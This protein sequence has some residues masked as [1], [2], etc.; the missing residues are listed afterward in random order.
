MSKLSSRGHLKLIAQFVLLGSI[1]FLNQN[2]RLIFHLRDC[3][4]SRKP[5]TLRRPCGGGVP[6]P[7]H[8][9][10]TW[11]LSR[12]AVIDPSKLTNLL[13]LLVC[14]VCSGTGRTHGPSLRTLSQVPLPLIQMQISTHTR[15]NA[16]MRIVV[17][18]DNTQQARLIL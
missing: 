5:L 16:I 11:R 15:A 10:M 9:C 8:S 1:E 4:H 2:Q 18:C 3:P 12:Y 6:R 14:L 17:E 7:Q 13:R